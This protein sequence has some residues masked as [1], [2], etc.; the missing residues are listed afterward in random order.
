[1]YGQVNEPSYLL[2]AQAET[3]FPFSAA[4]QRLGDLTR[5]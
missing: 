5:R 1:M 2:P 4:F 3:P